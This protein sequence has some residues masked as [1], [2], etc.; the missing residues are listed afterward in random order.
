MKSVFRIS[1]TPPIKATNVSLVNQPL[2]EMPVSISLP[3]A[4]EPLSHTP[5]ATHPTAANPG[6]PAAF[7]PLLLPPTT[8]PLARALPRYI[9]GPLAP[10]PHCE[11]SI[12]IALP[13]IPQSTIPSPANKKS[14]RTTPRPD[15][16]KLDRPPPNPPPSPPAP[17]KHAPPAASNPPT[18]DP[19]SQSPRREAASPAPARYASRHSAFESMPLSKA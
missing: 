16:P 19:Q 15:R 9:L 7:P 2:K 13:A 18:H 17:R 11:N 14:N 6:A 1:S 4:P 8:R 10:A 5:E 3:P 12:H